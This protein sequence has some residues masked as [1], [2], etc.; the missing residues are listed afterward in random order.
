MY[1]VPAI[2][3]LP[4]FLS[5]DRIP[6]LNVCLGHA[7][8]DFLGMLHALFH[9]V[10]CD[11]FILL[12]KSGFRYDSLWSKLVSYT[13]LAILMP[14]SLNILDLYFLK[15]VYN[16]CEK[17]ADGVKALLSEEAYRARKR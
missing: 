5:S 6:P 1:A 7:E 11:I 15:Q 14:I 10:L 9:F 12:G 3:L 17:Q 2:F 16:Q 13:L 4:I 8:L